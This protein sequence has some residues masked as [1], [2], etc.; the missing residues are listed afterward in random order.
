MRIEKLEI[1]CLNDPQI[2]YV[3]YEGSYQ[4]ALI[5]VHAENGTYGVGETDSPP[6]VIKA[7]IECPAYNVL[8]QGLASIIEGESLTTKED[9]KRLWQKM[10]H[11]TNWHGRYGIALHAI[12]AID[13]ALWDLLGKLNNRPVH[14]YLGDKKYSA[15]PAY[16]TIYP[17]GNDSKEFI[18]NIDKILEQGFKSIKVCAEEWW[19]DIPLAIEV[20]HQIRNFVGPEIDMMFDAAM[21][22]TL[23]EQIE[24]IIPTLENLNFKWIEAPF[25]ADNIDDHARLKKI[26]QLPIA[27][28]DVGLITTKEFLPFLQADAFDIAQPDLTLFGGISEA[29]KLNKILKKNNKRITPHCYNTDIML[30]ANIHFMCTNAIS[31]PMEYSTSNSLLRQKLIRNGSKI[32]KNG[33]LPVSDDPGLGIQLDWD[34]VDQFRVHF[35]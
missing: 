6:T 4:N 13:I 15:L 22:L 29:I 21:E 28:G 18:P 19:S 16:A 12:S 35:N 30:A 8:S 34:I 26:T 25:D 1:I 24:Q 14:S 23:F 11:H 3:R 33:M 20:L 17:T 7:L 2:D 10:Y 27:V 32:Q 9:I 5:V 31:E